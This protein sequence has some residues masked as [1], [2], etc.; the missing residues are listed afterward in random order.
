MRLSVVSDIFIFPLDQCLCKTGS[1][2]SNNHN[3]SFK[4][5]GNVQFHLSKGQKKTP[6]FFKDFVTFS[7]IHGIPSNFQDLLRLLIKILSLNILLISLYFIRKN[8]YPFIL[9]TFGFIGHETDLYVN[10]IILVFTVSFTNIFF[11]KIIICVP[12]VNENKAF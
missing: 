9:V 7:P 12:L 1:K 11:P 10:K 8:Q 2:I 6:N 5:N 4:D 3:F